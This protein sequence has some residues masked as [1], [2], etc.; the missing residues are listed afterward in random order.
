MMHYGADIG[1]ASPGV[2]KRAT[3][4]SAYPTLV[5]WQDAVRDECPNA[6]GRRNLR[7]RPC[8]PRRANG[9]FSRRLAAETMGK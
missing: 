2:Q 6:K 3:G 8:G 4:S 7:S 9:N 5:G 1:P